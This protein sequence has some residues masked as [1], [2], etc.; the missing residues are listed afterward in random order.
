M[1][2]TDVLFKKK[3]K[4]IDSPKI[5]EIGTLQW[6]M[7]V[8][9]HHGAWLPEGSTHIKSDVAPGGDVDVVSDAHDLKEFEDSS[10]DAFIAISVWEHL[11]KPWIAADAAHRVLK[12]GGLLY[13]ATHFAFPI[14]GYPSDYTRWTDKGLEALFDSPKWHSQK[15][16]FSFPCK[17]TPPKEVKVWNSA[18]PAYLNV[19]VFAIKS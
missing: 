5:L 6:V 15:S 14:H 4:L 3:I 13:V 1:S 16:V 2:E 17:I 12:P 19:S 9:T 11:R 18:A 7:G 10:F 8:S